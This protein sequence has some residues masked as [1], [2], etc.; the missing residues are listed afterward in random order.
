M[1]SP[2]D[3]PPLTLTPEDVECWAV[4]EREGRRAAAQYRFLPSLANQVS[5]LTTCDCGKR[6]MHEDAV[7]RECRRG[8]HVGA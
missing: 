5:F 3:W 2:Y 4:Y 7:C 8:D 6:T 1:P